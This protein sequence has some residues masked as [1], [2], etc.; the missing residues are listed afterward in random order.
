MMRQK[1]ANPL[2]KEN[3][4]SEKLKAAGGHAAIAMIDK[5]MRKCE[6]NI[7]AIEL[8]DEDQKDYLR[9][10]AKAFLAARMKKIKNVRN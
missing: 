9:D 7:R 10:N 4:A 5:I 1:I 3:A 8:L 6:A 2:K